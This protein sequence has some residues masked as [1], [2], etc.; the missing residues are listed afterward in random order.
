M[1]TLIAQVHQPRDRPALDAHFAAL[2]E[3]DLHFR[4]GYTIRPEAVQAY[5]DGLAATDAVAYGIY[6]PGGEL[7]ALAQLG[8]SEEEVEVGLSTLGAYRRQGLGMALMARA[9]SYARS[10]NLRRLV[11]I[12]LADNQPILALARRYGMTVKISYG[13]AH[14]SLRLEAGTALDFWREVAFDQAALLQSVR[15]NWQLATGRRTDD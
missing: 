6:N 1:Y 4:F 2:S 13:E 3:E 5:L 15:R 9:A 12:S 11:L 7:V 10:R 14:S 8:V